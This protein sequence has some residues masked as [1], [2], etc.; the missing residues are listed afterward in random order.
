M[1]II[2]CPLGRRALDSTD[3][4]LTKISPGKESEHELVGRTFG[5]SHRSIV[6]STF[7]C[8]GRIYVLHACIYP[9][10]NTM[11]DPLDLDEPWGR[12]G[13]KANSPTP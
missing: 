8:T 11:R 1:I 4:V 2:P 12:S 3:G 10:Q 13:G 6:A 5:P 9:S 7:K